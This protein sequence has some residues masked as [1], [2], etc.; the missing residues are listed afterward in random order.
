LQ[1]ALAEPQLALLAEMPQA[2]EQA[3]ADGAPPGAAA[4]L[5]E[6]ISLGADQM[7]FAKL[8]RTLPEQAEEEQGPCLLPR[9]E[10][11]A[12]E[13]QRRADLKELDVDVS[14]WVP[15]GVEAPEYLPPHLRMK[16]ARRANEKA[17]AAEFTIMPPVPAFAPLADDAPPATPQQ[18]AAGA[19]RRRQNMKAKEDAEEGGAVEPVGNKKAQRVSS[20]VR[21]QT[22]GG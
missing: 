10:A 9:E 21:L 16:A 17:K 4:L 6:A 2:L 3:A 22:A 18:Q 8:L 15:V 19:K 11:L 12:A 7:V 13:Q 14:T 5:R 20:Q 1:V